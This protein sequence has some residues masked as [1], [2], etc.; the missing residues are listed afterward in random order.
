MANYVKA[1]ENYKFISGVFE[2]SAFE[3][4]EMNIKVTFE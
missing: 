1:G 3:R 4:F 2:K